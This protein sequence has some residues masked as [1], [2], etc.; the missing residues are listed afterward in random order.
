MKLY[1]LTCQL[2][3]SC[4]EAW[5]QAM[6]QGLGTLVLESEDKKHKESSIQVGK[7]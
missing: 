7:T 4:L 3:T 1:L 5:Y 6:A 2:L